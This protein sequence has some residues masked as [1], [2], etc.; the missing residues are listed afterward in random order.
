MSQGWSCIWTTEP[1]PL[2]HWGKTRGWGRQ[3]SWLFQQPL[4]NACPLSPLTETQFP[5]SLASLL[6][7]DKISP[8]HITSRMCCS[9]G[10]LYEHTL[11]FRISS[12]LACASSCVCLP[13]SNPSMQPPFMEQTKMV[14]C[15]RPG[16]RLAHKSHPGALSLGNGSVAFKHSCLPWARGHCLNL[17]KLQS[18]CSLFL[19]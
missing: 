8:Q 18:Q 19:P 13:T 9:S 1:S 15:V 10:C 12:S 17:P 3:Q 16:Q 11:G 7:Q 2:K 14:F 6:L 5:L 4:H